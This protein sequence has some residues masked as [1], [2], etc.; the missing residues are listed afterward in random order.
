MNMGQL[1]CLPR[2]RREMGR[3]QSLVLYTL[4]RI[5]WRGLHFFRRGLEIKKHT[6]VDNNK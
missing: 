3:R 2:Q 1:K 5:G 6:H 4:S